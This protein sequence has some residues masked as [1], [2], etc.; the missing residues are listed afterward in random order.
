MYSSYI[1][2]KR[3][4]NKVKLKR[5][6]RSREGLGLIPGTMER[7]DITCH[8][9]D[10]ETFTVTF[11]A[12]PTNCTSLDCEE[13]T[14]CC[15]PTVLPTNYTQYA[16]CALFLCAKSILLA[17]K[18]SEADNSFSYQQQLKNICRSCRLDLV[19][20]LQTLSEQHDTALPT[21]G[22]LHSQLVTDLFLVAVEVI[23][24]LLVQPSFP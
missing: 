19:Y 11:T 7:G 15:E 9:A 23:E 2:L 3:F 12:N 24:G 21:S 4:R 14:S 17:L 5:N 13:P 18:S 22:L 20:H 16:E 1:V 6:E 10:T 8:E